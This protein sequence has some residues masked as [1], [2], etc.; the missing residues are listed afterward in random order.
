MSVL[1]WKNSG[2]KEKGDFFMHRILEEH[3]LLYAI[4]V[5]GLIG[6]ISRM[7][8]S[9]IMRRLLREAEN[10]G[11]T[12]QETLLLIKRKYEA[13]AMVNRNI[14]NTE[15]FVE[16]HLRRYQVG[17]MTLRRLG[18]ITYEMMLCAMILGFIGGVGAY[19]NDME[20]RQII[21]YPAAAVL[22]VMLLLFCEAFLE[23][24]GKLEQLKFLIVDYL[25]NTM[26][27]RLKLQNGLAGKNQ[28]DKSTGMLQKGGEAASHLLEKG[29][30]EPPVFEENEMPGNSVVNEVTV[31]LAWE[32]PEEEKLVKEVL[33][34]YLT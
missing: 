15:A 12:G 10:M 7:V 17:G 33:D 21:L 29:V 25:D 22:I 19:F 28:E 32:S 31:A 1:Y 24:E 11:N 34:E 2:R 9:R 20:I 4:L 14:T 30:M 6:L 5:T 26:E 18:A 13:G 27:P 16:R 3:Y 23:L 8:L